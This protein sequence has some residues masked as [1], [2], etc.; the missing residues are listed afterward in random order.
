VRTAALFAGVVLLTASCTGDGN[1]RSP[2]ASLA[3][4]PATQPSPSPS[5]ALPNQSLGIGSRTPTDGWVVMADGFGVH[6]AGG[7]TLQNV[8]PETGRSSEVARIGSWD[9]DFAT[10]GRYGEGSLWLTSGHD[11]WFVGGSPHYAIGRRYDLHS[12]GYLGSVHQASPSAGGGTWIA[13]T[14]DRHASGLI[15]ELDPD[16][17]AIL[18]RFVA[19]GGSGTITDAGGF[20]VAQTGNGV[21]RIDP[22][23]GLETTKRL[24]VSPGGLAVSDDRI[25]WTSGRGAINCLS[26]D[27]L[28]DCGTVY[29][30]R[31]TALSSDGTRLWVLSATGSRRTGTYVPDPSQPA[32]V[33][34]MNGDTGDVVAGP[35][36]LPHHTPASL[37]SYGG[38]AWVGFHDAQDVL[39]IDVD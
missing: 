28:T 15:A 36:E 31:A 23:T 7:G 20:I 3:S 13:A 29:A 30:P 6:V 27:S 17:G 26:V 35:L 21:L 32:T 1:I 33:T 39:R 22:R 9:Y 19:R 34:L 16:S 38:H 10:L 18:R 37:T 2:S 25:W 12:L 24:V 4:S 11:L 8:D 5:T 14:G